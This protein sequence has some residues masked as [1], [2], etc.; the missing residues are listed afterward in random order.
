[1]D[2]LPDDVFHHIFNNLDISDIGIM[3]N[4]CKRFHNMLDI[5]LKEKLTFITGM[6]NI[7]NFNKTQLKHL[8]KSLKRNN[9]TAGEY[10]SF[11]LNNNGE[12]Y[13]FGSNTFNCLGIGSSK[14]N[15]CDP[16][17]I[18]DNILQVSPG[19]FFSLFLTK[20]GQVYFCGEDYQ[21]YIT[22]K[23]E[24]LNVNN[25]VQISSNYYHSLL[26]NNKG[27]VYMFGNTDKYQPTPTLIH[28]IDNIIQVSC[29][30][31]FSLLLNDLGQVYSFGINDCKQL[32]RN[33][34]S[35]LPT[36]IPQIDNI[37]QISCGTNH[38][39][40]LDDKGNVYGFGSNSFGQLGVKETDSILPKII[41]RLKNIKQIA[42]GCYHSICLDKLGNVYGFGL[43]MD[44]QL[45]FTGTNYQF[46]PTKL[47]VKNT[48]QICCGG[49]HTLLLDNNNNIYAF[50]KNNHGQL[51][52]N[53]GFKCITNPIIISNLD[54]F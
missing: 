33:Y 1:M 28:D 13:G 20:N 4:V 12:V 5:V 36:I 19:Y 25:I 7:N 9:I 6:I 22:S 17:L 10:N 23:L 29:G 27:Q 39:L 24:L 48:K 2:I 35:D 16:I 45:G 40:A 41:P 26:L 8:Y 52:V 21:R 15:T 31:N 43:N 53:N 14:N 47:E 34:K 49:Y 38:S 37:I 51:G 18:H 11:I 3:F 30:H 46:G 32:G 54:E 42:C 44:Y 50:G